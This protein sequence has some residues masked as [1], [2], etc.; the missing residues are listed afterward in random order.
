MKSK[1]KSVRS[2]SRIAAPPQVQKH[3]SPARKEGRGRVTLIL[4]CEDGAEYAR[5][6]VPRSLYALIEQAAKDCGCSLADWIHRAVENRIR[7][8]KSSRS[9]KCPEVL[10][11]F[12]ALND[13]PTCL[14]LFDREANAPV[15][16]VPLGEIELANLLLSGVKHGRNGVEVIADLLRASPKTIASSVE[17]A[18]NSAA[19]SAVDGCGF[20]DL[21]SA[22]NKACA[23]L[24]ASSAKSVGCWSAMVRGTPAGVSEP[25]PMASRKKQVR[26]SAVVFDGA[27]I[28]QQADK[29][30]EDLA[31]K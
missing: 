19:E 17:R 5:L 8:L 10:G 21:E 28:E 2:G 6:D 18:G 24:E 14:C 27:Q 26:I 3:S 16:K 15:V 30:Q 1:L 23:L 12:D 20:M 25:A 11:P 7:S 31:S 13:Y 22:V 4:Q 9:A 29:T